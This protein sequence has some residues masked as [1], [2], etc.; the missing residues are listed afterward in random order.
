M[1]LYSSSYGYLRMCANIQKYKN[2]QIQINNNN[3]NKINIKRFN[4]CFFQQFYTCR[5]SS[6]VGELQVLSNTEE[7]ELEI[8]SYIR[9]CKLNSTR[10]YALADNSGV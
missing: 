6:K 7:Q 3:N 2:K 1:N 9:D 8:S 5:T 4:T 10:E